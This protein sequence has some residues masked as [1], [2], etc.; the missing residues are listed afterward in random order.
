M[1]VYEATGKS[2]IDTS[3]GYAM[4]R[5]PVRKVRDAPH[6][7]VDGTSCIAGLNEIFA[8]TLSETRKIAAPQPRLRLRP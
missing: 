3:Y 5:E 8:V 7:D 6:V 2:I 4:W 1:A